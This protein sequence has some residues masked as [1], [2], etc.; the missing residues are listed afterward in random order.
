MVRAAFTESA[1]PRL[2]TQKPPPGLRDCGGER[3]SAAGKLIGGFMSSFNSHHL[4]RF[5]VFISIGS[6]C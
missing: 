2:G 4:H 6:S 5:V 3:E 1:D